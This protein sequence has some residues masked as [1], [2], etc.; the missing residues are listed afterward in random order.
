MIKV[1]AFDVDGT[2]TH[3]NNEMS[4][5]LNE[6]LHV[7]MKRGLKILLV[8][9]RPY[10]DLKPFQE[11]NHFFT[12]A[13]VLNGA[14]M[15]NEKHEI[16]MCKY[17]NKTI[18]KKVA[19][20]LQAADLPFVCYTKKGNIEYTCSKKSYGELLKYYLD[21]EDEIQSLIDS[22]HFVDASFDHDEVFKLEVLF[23][24]LSRIQEIKEKLKEIQGIHV[25]TSMNFNLEITALDTT[26]GAVLSEYIQ[27]QGYHQ[28]EVMIF[29]DSEN[30]ITLFEL[31]ENTVFVENPKNHFHPSSKYRALSSE[32]DG[33]YLFLK[34]YFKES[35]YMKG[36]Y[37][38]R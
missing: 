19:E 8:T 25:T 20:T 32:E 6:M 9:G 12:P 3:A 36:H 23:E 24:D 7:L 28:D 4:P 33:V 11:K 13:I 35:S 21:D 31:F 17:M 16:Q 22:F 15:M 34:E 37:D 30:D 2:L 14:V 18:V 10:E 1:L 26:K 38:R 5:T 27:M 29:G